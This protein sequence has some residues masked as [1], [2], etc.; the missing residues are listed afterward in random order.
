MMSNPA[1]LS[2]VDRIVMLMEEIAIA[3]SKLQ[4]HD[5]G[6]I[7]TAINYMRNRVNEI[8]KDIEYG[9]IQ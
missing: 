7:H 1:I 5:T 8:K 6:H 9:E 4:P 2:D 3:Q